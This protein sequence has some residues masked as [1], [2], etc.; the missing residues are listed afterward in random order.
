MINSQERNDR[1]QISAIERKTRFFDTKGILI[2]VQEKHQQLCDGTYLESQHKIKARRLR[3]PGPHIECQAWLSYH[4]VRTLK[5]R[6][7][8]EVVHAFNP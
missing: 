8:N 4:I 5:N 2:N 1:L 3:P 6:E 7:L